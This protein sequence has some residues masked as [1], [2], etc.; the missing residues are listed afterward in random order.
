M[1]E[2]GVRGARMPLVHQLSEK[3]A[4]SPRLSEAAVQGLLPRYDDV[5][6]YVASLRG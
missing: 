5:A 2:D 6:A 3:G 1:P 4:V